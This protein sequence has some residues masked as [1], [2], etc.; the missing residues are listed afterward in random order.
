MML[1]ALSWLVTSRA[2]RTTAL[3]MLAVL[4]AAAVIA[5]A[6]ARGQ[7]AERARQQARTLKTLQARIKTDDTIAR[8]SPDARR[9]AL[10]EWVSDRGEQ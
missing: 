3:V 1:S 4:S 7:A 9:R 10:A 5:Q 2:G 8:M 6:F